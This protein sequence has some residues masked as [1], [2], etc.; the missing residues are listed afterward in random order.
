MTRINQLAIKDGNSTT[1]AD[2]RSD[3]TENA[4]VVVQNTLPDVNIATLPDVAISTL[5]DVN[6]ATLPDVNLATGS[7]V[8]IDTLP[9][10]NVA[11]LPDVRVLN[12]TASDLNATVTGTVDIGTLPAVS[13]STLPSI[14]VGTLPDIE[15][16]VGIQGYR[17]SDSTY[18]PATLDGKTNVLVTIDYPHYTIH[19]GNHFMYTD[20]VELDN[21]VSQDY[22]ITV[23]DTAKNPHLTFYL[24]GSAITQWQFYEGADRTGTTPQT[25]GNNNRNSLTAATTTLHKGTSGGSTD[26]NLAYQYKGGSATNQAKIGSDSGNNEELILARNTKYILR[27]TSYTDDNLTN[28]RLEWYEQTDLV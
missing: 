5:P 2:V 8:S 4:L 12:A 22:L 16:V 27:V 7:I 1:V 21:G 6:V 26:G 11:T 19:Q 24:D 17:T 10:V 23:P 18:Q 14:T 15:G 13:V 28:M 3:G 9:D 25:I 20:S